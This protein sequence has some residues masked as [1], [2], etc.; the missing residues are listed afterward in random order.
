[1]TKHT[2]A[3]ESCGVSIEGELY[4]LGLSNMSCMYC[5]SCPSVLLIKDGDLASR[6]GIERP[7]LRAGDEGWEYYDRHLL[8]FY[9]RYE[10]LFKP[11]SCGGRYH[12]YALPRCPECNGYILGGTPEPDKP[13]AWL[14]RHVF[15]T[16]GS[17]TDS[18]HVREIGI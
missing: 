14:R 5:D 11:C 6:H 7:Y 10:A 13:I 12:A 3:C 16:T 1:M 9:E 2:Q 4:H 18:E 17:V 8:P 15:I